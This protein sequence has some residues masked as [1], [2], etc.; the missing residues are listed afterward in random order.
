ML[1]TC[2]STRLEQAHK[3]SFAGQRAV[4]CVRGGIDPIPPYC[5]ISYDA[6]ISI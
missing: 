5:S 4:I 3:A 1:M 2:G 6:E